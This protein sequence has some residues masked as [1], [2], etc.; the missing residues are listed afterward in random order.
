[1]SLLNAPKVDGDHYNL[2]LVFRIHKDANSLLIYKLLNI[3]ICYIQR[4]RIGFSAYEA[5]WLWENETETSSVPLY[6][7][8]GVISNTN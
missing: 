8:K 6:L 1:M 4:E 2:K 3:R 7:W 5:H